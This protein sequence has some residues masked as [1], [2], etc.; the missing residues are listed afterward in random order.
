LDEVFVK[1]NGVLHY[2]WRAVDQDGDELDI[3]VQKRRN[4]KAAMKFFNNLLKGQQTT[5]MKIVTDKLRSYSAANRDIMPSVGHSTQQ[6][7]NNRCELS[8]QP[9]RQQERQMRRFKSQGQPQ[10]F[11]S[12]HGIVNNMFRLGRHHMN[13]RDLR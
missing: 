1:V 8:H 3:L 4:K 11:L 7:E 13:A 12:C 6:Y 9:G 2:L 5:T 10:R